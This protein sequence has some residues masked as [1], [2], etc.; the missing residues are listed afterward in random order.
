MELVVP[1]CVGGIRGLLV[2]SV[3]LLV[4]SG[5]CS[6]SMETR[7]F[8]RIQGYRPYKKRQKTRV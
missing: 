7:C 4:F 8:F 5:R 6:R 3:K 1:P 2:C